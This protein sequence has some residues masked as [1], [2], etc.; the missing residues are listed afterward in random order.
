MLTEVWPVLSKVHMLKCG[1][2]PS[3]GT[4]S[5][6]IPGSKCNV[7]L[8]EWAAEATQMGKLHSQNRISGEQSAG[9]AGSWSLLRL[10]SVK[11]KQDQQQWGRN[12]QV[13]GTLCYPSARFYRE[14]F[15][16]IS[17][18]HTHRGAGRWSVKCL[19]GA[20]CFCPPLCPSEKVINC[21][22][23]GK[24]TQAPGTSQPVLE[25]HPFCL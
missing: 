10:T 23:H 12:T 8:A 14:A 13:W 5:K 18:P 11:W 15:W 24:Q 6:R 21:S 3:I 22:R 7:I 16:D 4:Q 2:P 17:D 9:Q 20:W 25:S 19:Q 1:G